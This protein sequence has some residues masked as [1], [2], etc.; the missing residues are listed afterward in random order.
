MALATSYLDNVIAIIRGEERPD[1]SVGV[2]VTYQSTHFLVIGFRI[3]RCLI[4][5]EI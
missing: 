1:S 3:N 5:Y 2:D 4:R